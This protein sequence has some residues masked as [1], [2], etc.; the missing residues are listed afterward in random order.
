MNSKTIINA[1]L[2][3]LVLWGIIILGVRCAFA[4]EWVA[5]AYC[6]CEKCCGKSDGITASGV[7]AHDGTVACN[8]LPFGT[9]LLIDGKLYTVED[10]GS[11]K[12]FGTKDEQRKRVDIWFPSHKQALKYGRKVVNVTRG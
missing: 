12:H 3:S 4:E 11:K 6:S 2:I 9:N 7:K 8:W 1:L 5:T 10:R